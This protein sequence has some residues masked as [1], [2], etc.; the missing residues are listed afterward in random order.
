VAAN[1][2]GE[3]QY[4][5]TFRERFSLSDAELKLYAMVG[6]QRIIGDFM[7]LLIFTLIGDCIHAMF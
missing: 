4:L 1:G 2:R 5:Y 3:G 6:F 7:A